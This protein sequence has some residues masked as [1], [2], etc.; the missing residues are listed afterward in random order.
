MMLITMMAVVV[1]EVVV[2]VVEMV[3]VIEAVEVVSTRQSMPISNASS[4]FFDDVGIIPWLPTPTGMWSNTACARRSFSPLS[5]SLSRRLVR[6]SRTPQLMSKPA[7]MSQ[8]I[9]AGRARMCT[10]RRRRV[11]R[12]TRGWTWGERFS[13]RGRGGSVVATCRTRRRFQS[14]SRSLHARRVNQSTRRQCPAA[15]PRWLI[16]S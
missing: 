9:T 13:G 6:S 2:E 5:M 3:E 15:R 16:A 8:K 10:H 12:L 1:V 14:R 4:K 11:T 7:Q